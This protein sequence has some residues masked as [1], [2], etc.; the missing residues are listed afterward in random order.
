MENHYQNGISNN[1]STSNLSLFMPP[2]GKDINHYHTNL[3]FILHAYVYPIIYAVGIPGNL[4]SFA[5]WIHPK[6]RNSS[7]CYFAAI[8][9]YDTIVLLLHLIVTIHL[10]GDIEILDSDILC[11]GFNVVYLSSE[12]MAVLLVLGLTVDRYI[13][14]HFPMKKHNFCTKSRSVK[15]IV[16]LTV[17][18]L[19]LGITE[20]S[21][22]TYDKV[23]H[24]CI[25][26]PTINMRSGS[27]IV[28]V[29]NI[30]ILIVGILLPVLL[31]LVLNLV[32]V[33]ELRKILVAR[34][35]M[36]GC[37]EHKRQDNDSTIMLL[38]LSCYLIL[39]EIPDSIL[40]LLKPFFLPPVL[41]IDNDKYQNHSHE[42]SYQR[43]NERY[44]NYL[45]TAAV[46]GTFSLTNYAINILIYS[47]AGH[48]FRHTLIKIFKKTGR[49]TPNSHSDDFS[50][51]TAG[52]NQQTAGGQSPRKAG[53]SPT[54]NHQYI[55]L[56]QR[57]DG[58][59]EYN[60]VIE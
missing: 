33:N 45:L 39:S 49:S 54:C 38:A 42:S 47:L 55:P 14:V 26:R 10:V 32:I 41:H 7:A 36:M 15:V 53:Y 44:E 1:L 31:V 28:E 5:M 35:Q 34:K 57:N 50:C 21:F 40:Y 18:A 37:R 29:G 9:I 30:T 22:W 43:A 46:F 58:N 8:A 51:N 59:I 4:I 17:F 2:G 27:H 23:A 16:C 6:L 3:E 52:V 19:V 11:E 12:I 24:E 60:A 48:K 25:T 13:I 20:G 56:Q